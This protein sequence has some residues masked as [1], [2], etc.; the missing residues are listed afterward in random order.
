MNSKNSKKILLLATTNQGKLVELQKL[1]AENEIDIVT[2]ADVDVVK[3][4]DV[5]EDGKTFKANAIKKAKE[6]GKIAEMLT[7]ADDSGLIVDALEGRPGVYS[8]RYGTTDSERN[9]KLLS[10]LKEVSDGNR[11]AR[12]VA[13][14]AV[15]DPADDRVYTSKG[16]V[17]GSITHSPTGD[18]GFGYD[19]VFFSTE[20][21]KTFAEASRDEKNQVSHRGRA[22]AQIRP[23]LKQLLT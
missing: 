14:M 5:V 11:T 19:P 12:F 7:L 17:E 8:K 10:E 21:K 4:M 20:L 16:V 2:L 15:Y 23:I 18:K 9:E 3:N 1:F 22:I 13:V 6:Y